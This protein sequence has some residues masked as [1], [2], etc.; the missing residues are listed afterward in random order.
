MSWLTL[1][2]IEEVKGG[3]ARFFMMTGESLLDLI[4]LHSDAR[5]Y[6]SSNYKVVL[7]NND[8]IV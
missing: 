1:V 6:L 5:I 3:G 4:F 7:D 2:V 8:G